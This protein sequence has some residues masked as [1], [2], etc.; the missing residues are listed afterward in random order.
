MWRILG[1]GSPTEASSTDALSTPLAFRSEADECRSE[2]ER[3]DSQA[4][5]GKLET[6]EQATALLPSGERL[7]VSYCVA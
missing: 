1:G 7:S 4:W 6:E 2:A 5:Q 3:V